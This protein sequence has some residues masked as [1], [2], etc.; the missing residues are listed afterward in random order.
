[1]SRT[2]HIDNDDAFFDFDSYEPLQPL[3]LLEESARGTQTPR[4]STGSPS[5][6]PL[7][8]QDDPPSNTMSNATQSDVK[9]KRVSYSALSE[10]MSIPLAGSIDP[11]DDF[12]AS[13]AGQSS[14]STTSFILPVSQCAI[15]Q[16]SFGIME[17]PRD[18]QSTG[19]DTIGGGKG[20]GREL[21][22]TLPPLSFSPTEFSYAS[23]DWPAGPSSY[24]SSYASAGDVEPRSLSSPLAE[25]HPPIT[26]DTPASPAPIPL[27]RRRTTSNI[28][29]YSRHSISTP[30]LSKVKVKFAGSKAASGTLAR[31]LLFRK[32]PPTSPRPASA[33]FE[34]ND[35]HGSSLSPALADLGYVGQNSCLIPW[36]REIKSRSPLASP[37]VETNSVWGVVDSPPTGRLPRLVDPLPMRT[38]GRSYS[39]PLPFQTSAFDIVPLAPADLCEPP[40]PVLTNHFDEY[41]P[42][43]LKLQ[44][45]TALVDLH[46]I[47]HEKRLR[48]GKWT[49][50]KA[51]SSKSKWVGKERGFRE[52]FK[53]S[54][55]GITSNLQVLG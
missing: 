31:K 25:Q 46:I 8:I 16:D 29:K 21:P 47:E 20:K 32:S 48:D 17:V 23:S 28:S 41:L 26:P 1:M 55:V 3:S 6:T 13:L 45:L 35:V 51:S 43:E 33:N 42:H 40:P 36:S 9:G 11:E 14:T 22:P 39:S 38:K 2:Q 19:P 12:F 37:V 5:S 10:P 7:Y 53:L 52:L 15:P 18:E 30:T 49:V 44:V 24:S 50:L 54:R 4:I 27:S 34:Q